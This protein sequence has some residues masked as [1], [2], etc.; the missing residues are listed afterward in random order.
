[1][2][3]D[4]SKTTPNLLFYERSELLIDGDGEKSTQKKIRKKKYAKKNTQKIVR[5]N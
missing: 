3:S 5:E 2:R 4:F 1:M